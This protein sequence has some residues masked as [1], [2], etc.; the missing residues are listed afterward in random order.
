MRQHTM[1]PRPTRAVSSLLRS[2][3]DIFFGPSTGHNRDCSSLPTAGQVSI[4][5]LTV[6]PRCIHIFFSGILTRAR[7]HRHFFSQWPNMTDIFFFLD[8]ARRTNHVSTSPLLLMFFSART[9]VYEPHAPSVPQ[10]RHL[11]ITADTLPSPPLFLLLFSLHL[12]TISIPLTSSP[13][14]PGP[15]H[16]SQL[17]D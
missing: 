7:I 13:S 6:G 14:T 5:T 16:S 12:I 11:P 17:R 2:A 1:R 4:P 8:I 10:L 3:T 9:V 15:T